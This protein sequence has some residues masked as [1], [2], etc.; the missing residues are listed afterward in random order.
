[1]KEALKHS[2]IVL[3]ALFMI[4][5]LSPRSLSAAAPSTP[6][7]QP[8]ANGAAQGGTSAPAT[9]S[10][11][12]A[13]PS[14]A[15]LTLEAP[16]QLS[17]KPGS[18]IPLV[19]GAKLADAPGIS[20]VA[21]PFVD[22]STM[23]SLQAS[24]CIAESATGPCGKNP[25]IASNALG[26]LWLV[27]DGNAEPGSY[28]GTIR[29]V[30][31]NGLQASAPITL[32]ISTERW[33]QRGLVA[34]IL[35][36]AL[37]FLM[38]VWLPQQ[39]SRDLAL[40]PFVHLQP[41]VLTVL[42]L[43]S[44][45]DTASIAQA[46]ALLARLRSETLESEGLI[47]PVWPAAKATLPSADAVTAYMDDAQKR[48]AALEL[49]ADGLDRAPDAATR[50][51]IDKLAAANG[52]P[53]DDL[54]IKINQLL[55]INPAPGAP[56]VSGRGITPATLVLREEVRNFSYWLVSSILSV[57]LGYVLLVDSN[58]SFGGWSDVASAFLW[59]LGVAT[60]GTK[61]AD[62]SVAQLR[63]GLQVP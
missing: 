48:L 58:A 24:F 20:V 21:G 43:F 50:K 62:V 18:R 2:V 33:Q 25:A 55:G 31:S 15:A 51:K 11:Q 5:I 7:V 32:N 59:G 61:L 26:Q 63:G 22:G 53:Q 57:A 41:R 40:A 37:S 27:G 3:V 52:F 39:K 28:V 1:M 30:A 14:E 56:S 44:D 49:L 34:L 54:G 17:W 36:V 23:K 42:G 46:K 19:V 38:S 10:G 9:Q 29:L 16:A 13:L 60:A 35:G 4:A 6:V 47:P 45:G 8:P 12:P